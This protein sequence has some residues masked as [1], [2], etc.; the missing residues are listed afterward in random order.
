MPTFAAIICAGNRIIAAIGKHVVSGQTLAGG[1]VIICT[2]KSTPGG[3]VIP[4]LEIIQACFLDQV[5]ASTPN[6]LMA[7]F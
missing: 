1:G 4:A 6:Q 2:N 7:G 5:I 3:I